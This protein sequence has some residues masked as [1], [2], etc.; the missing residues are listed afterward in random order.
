MHFIIVCVD[1]KTSFFVNIRVTHRN[2]DRVHT[3]IH[4][5]HIE[6]LKADPQRCDIDD[7]ES[8]RAHGEGL[9]QP[10]KNSEMGWDCFHG[11][12]PDIEN[13]EG[14]PVYAV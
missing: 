8:S 10:I 2:H 1:P 6:N 3:N 11:W 12:V 5:N 7:V 14:G 4:H 13:F 9:E